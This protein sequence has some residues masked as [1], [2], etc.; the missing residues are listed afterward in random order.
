MTALLQEA[1][2]KARAAFMQ[3]QALAAAAERAFSAIRRTRDGAAGGVTDL[4]SAVEALGVTSRA[5]EAALR[6]ARESADR[7]VDA[8]D[9]GKL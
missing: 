9:A 7:L 1:E 5:A 3:A 2:A 6:D 8:L 4:R